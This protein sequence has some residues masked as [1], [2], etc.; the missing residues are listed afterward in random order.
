MSVGYLV[1][2]PLYIFI[3]D[4]SAS[5]SLSLCLCLS[6]F[7]S[8]FISQFTGSFFG[9]IDVLYCTSVFYFIGFF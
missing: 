2:S 5:L 9:F 1:L 3:S 8:N 6:L 4:L 7:L